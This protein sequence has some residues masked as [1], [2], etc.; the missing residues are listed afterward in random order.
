MKPALLEK[1]HRE[2]KTYWWHISC[3]LVWDSILRR[4]FNVADAKILDVGCG[5][6]INLPLLSRFGQVLGVDNS[7]QAV[8][9]YKEY[10][11]QAVLSDATKLSLPSESQDLV[12]AF[13]ILEHLDDD[14]KAVKE[15]C[16]VLK[17][18]GY[19]FISVPAYQWLFGPRDIELSHR[20]RYS[21]GGLVEL[22]KG[23]DCQVVFSSYFFALSF[24]PFLIQRFISKLISRSPGYT[25]A[26][27]VVNQFLIWLGQIEAGWLK[28]LPLPFGSSVLVLARKQKQ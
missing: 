13:D 3:R 21:R 1:M 5:T 7:P 4:F 24:L 12:T 18:G 27:P 22:T 8:D 15:W 6:G 23:T 10:G 14:A 17:P 28:I 16:R 2:E 9:F 20:R 25:P 19:L 26:P 11:G